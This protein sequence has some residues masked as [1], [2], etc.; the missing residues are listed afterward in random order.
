MA[1]L[2]G[3]T[4]T[5]AGCSASSKPSARPTVPTEWTAFRSSGLPNVPIS[6]AEY[7]APSE[8]SLLPETLRT[9]PKLEQIIR[10]SLDRPLAAKPPATSSGPH[11]KEVLSRSTEEESSN[12]GLGQDTH[13]DDKVETSST[14][15]DTRSRRSS[16]PEQA[17]PKFRSI[18]HDLISS[19]VSKI[20]TLKD[21][22]DRDRV[23]SKAIK[24]LDVPAETTKTSECTSCFEDLPL[25]DLVNL[26]CTHNY[27]KPCLATLI[28]TALQNES[29][30]PPKCCLSELPAATVIIPLDKKQRELYKE[31]AAEYSIP[32]DK[33]WY[34][35]LNTL[36]T[37]AHMLPGTV[38]IRSASNGFH[39]A[40]STVQG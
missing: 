8:L 11:R 7:D 24:K 14:A 18:R 31:K 25:S 9:P 17:V 5:E 40:N 2:D 20:A 21:K 36:L 15:S 34:A 35:T 26:P 38:L 1:T 37:T 23:A 29:A 39:Q 6:W 3:T 28:M 16:S 30:F 4:T 12:V 19:A 22:H 27:C 13:S 33:R 32:A 10:W